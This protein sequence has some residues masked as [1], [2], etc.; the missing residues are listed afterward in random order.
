LEDNYEE[1]KRNQG[2]QAIKEKHEHA[3]QKLFAETNA[4]HTSGDPI[5][6]GQAQYSSAD[7]EPQIGFNETLSQ[8][9]QYAGFWLRFLALVIDFLIFVLAGVIL[10]F[11][12]GKIAGS[13][14]I[15]DIPFFIASWLYYALMESSSRQ[16][17]IGKIV[18]GISVTNLSGNRISFGRA[19][20]RYFA[21]IISGITLSIGYIMAAFTAKRQTLHDIIASTVVIKNQTREN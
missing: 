6:H 10:G 14:K 15:L 12:V 18:L 20:G 3:S 5:I 21:K 8:P 17:T 19:T 7:S 2:C 11:F 1:I 13:A 16:A 4:I 9:L